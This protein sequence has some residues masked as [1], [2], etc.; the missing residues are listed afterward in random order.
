MKTIVKESSSISSNDA[1]LNK[2]DV[3]QLQLEII[4]ELLDKLKKDVNRYYE[5]KLYTLKKMAEF[6]EGIS[7]MTFYLKA[8]E[9]CNAKIPYYNRLIKL[10][11]EEI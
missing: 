3:K 1:I 10:L 7:D 5:N 9:T 4:S 2:A 8:L 6:K 11:E